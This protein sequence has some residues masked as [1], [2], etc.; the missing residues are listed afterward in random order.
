MDFDLS[1]PVRKKSKKEYE[2]D[3]RPIV[4]DRVGYLIGDEFAR[5]GRHLNLRNEDINNIDYNNRTAEAKAVAVLNQWTQLNGL[6]RWIQLKEKLISFKRVDIVQI[7]E[8]EFRIE[9][10]NSPETADKKDQRSQKGLSKCVNGGTIGKY[11][12]QSGRQL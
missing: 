7:V 11:S 3:L 9:T 12:S 2:S 6:Q 8:Q 5:F 1:E 10:L 4:I